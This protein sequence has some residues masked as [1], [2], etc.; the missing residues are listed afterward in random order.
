[1]L[2]A[3]NEKNYAST[4]ISKY[5]SRRNN[6]LNVA[7]SVNQTS[8]IKVSKLLRAYGNEDNGS[9]EADLAIFNDKRGEKPLINVFDKIIRLAVRTMGTLAIFL[10]IISGVLMVV[11]QGDDN[12]LEQAKT[13]FIYT[14]L[15]LIIGF[16]S[17][18]IVRFVIDT[19]LS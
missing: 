2:I 14:L 9:K 19:L 7:V 16:L 1:L 12:Q 13:V 11:S 3:A 18:T 10:L 5:I 4:L 8:H 15:G 17:Y 6:D